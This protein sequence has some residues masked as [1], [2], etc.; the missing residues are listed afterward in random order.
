MLYV[1]PFVI[2]PSTLTDY[3]LVDGVKGGADGRDLLSLLMHRT[4][5]LLELIHA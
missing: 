1:D 5:A 3:S 2:R 4:R